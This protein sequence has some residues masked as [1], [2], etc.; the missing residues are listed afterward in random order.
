ML[1]SPTIYDYLLQITKG[2]SGKLLAKVAD[3]AIT[4]TGNTFNGICKD[5]D[6]ASSSLAQAYLTL[7]VDSE[8]RNVDGLKSL[9]QAH[10]FFDE[11]YDDIEKLRQ[12]FESES[13]VALAESIR[14]KHLA[15]IGLLT[16][17]ATSSSRTIIEND[18]EPSRQLEGIDSALRLYAESRI[19]TLQ[20]MIKQGKKAHM[21]IEGDLKEYLAWF[22]YEQAAREILNGV[23]Q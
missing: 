14:P 22:G 12:R 7:V 18:G 11:F 6:R 8:A 16:K 10:E 21:V 17:V 5:N 4:A 23:I 9:P 1:N 3:D 19:A 15:E 2:N 13:S 20:A